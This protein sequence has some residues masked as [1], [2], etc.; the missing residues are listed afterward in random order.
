MRAMSKRDSIYVQLL[1]LLVLSAL[2][3]GAVYLA[4]SVAGSMV[5]EEYY[6]KSDYEGRKNRKYI[7][8]LQTFVE[9]QGLSSRDT[10]ELYSW[11]AS[12][13]IL[14]LHVYKDDILVFDSE[15]PGEA[16]WGEGITLN[17]YDWE[18]Y[19]TIQF[20]DGEGKVSIMGAYA[21]QF[22]T[23]ALIA[24][25]LI[26]FALFL[27]LVVL[28]IRKKMKYIRQLCEEVEILEGGSLDYKITVKGRD[29]LAALA[30]GLDNMRKSF[31]KLIRQEEDILR[32]SQ[33]IVTEMSHD[34]RTPVTSIM[35]YTE[36]LK[37]GKA[38]SEE[39]KRDYLE[40][41][42]KKSR[43]MKQLI[44][45]LFEYSLVTGESEIQLEAPETYEV[46]FY[47][48]FSETCSYLEQSGFQVEFKAQ[49]IDRRLRVYTSY[50]A[51]IMDNITS[52]II[53]YADPAF[54]VTIRTKYAKNM[55]GF[56]I[57][58]VRK[59]ETSREESTCVGLQSIKSMMVKMGGVCEIRQDGEEF[60]LEIRFPCIK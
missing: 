7:E 12:Q 31:Q 34:L 20:A 25:L 4:M 30:E 5:I 6:Y 15:H 14:L 36:I 50:I 41:I 47:D 27:A 42:D 52:N 58:N 48:L 2:V 33:R 45:H 24:E 60:E 54:P 13:K 39:Q 21:Y 49:W 1:R 22:Y 8:E 59:Q 3:A 38:K 37:K 18:V 17:P 9:E 29:E 57:A 55:A 16:V 28:G 11:V 26:S 32:E 44:D 19:Y 53:K 43:R 51:R 40:R 35:L 23:Y 46:L 10:Q 56:S